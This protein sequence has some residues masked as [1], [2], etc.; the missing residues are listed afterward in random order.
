MTIE[1]KTGGFEKKIQEEILCMTKMNLSQYIVNQLTIINPNFIALEWNYYN[2]I[3][4]VTNKDGERTKL[5]NINLYRKTSQLLV[6][7]MSLIS[8]NVLVRT[9]ELSKIREKSIYDKR[10]YHK[11]NKE[12]EKILFSHEKNDFR[13]QTPLE[14]N[15]TILYVPYFA[16]FLEKYS[17]FDFEVNKKLLKINHE[18]YT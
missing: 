16:H 9:N 15:K 12:Y 13:S 1:F 6:T 4:I 7:L 10:K 3:S 14:I 17:N 2:G 18:S 11:K 5:P 8:E